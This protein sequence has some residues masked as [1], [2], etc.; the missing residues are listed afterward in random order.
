[1]KLY[2][3]SGSDYSGQTLT[4]KGNDVDDATAPTTVLQYRALDLTDAGVDWTV[5]S[6]SGGTQY[7]SP[8]IASV[9]SEIVGR[10]GWVENNNLQ[11]LLKAPTTGTSSSDSFMIQFRS[12]NY[13]SAQAPELVIS[14]SEATTTT[15][16][17][18]PASDDDTVYK[19]VIKAVHPAAFSL[20]NTAN[21]EGNR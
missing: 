17:E 4:V 12:R 18:A 8:N 1:M 21:T 19:S 6:M 15:T 2:Y 13:S 9:I 16:T 5:G 10:A 3:H 11:L 7:T 14:Y 20:I